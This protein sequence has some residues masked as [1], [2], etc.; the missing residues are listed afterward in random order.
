MLY[1]LKQHLPAY[2]AHVSLPP[3]ERQGRALDQFAHGRPSKSNQGQRADAAYRVALQRARMTH[4][5]EPERL[6]YAE[7]ERILG[8]CMER[9][10]EVELTAITALVVGNTAFL[11]GLCLGQ[12]AVGALAGAVGATSLGATALAALWSCRAAAW[13]AQRYPNG[14]SGGHRLGGG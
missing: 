7:Y 11:A 13:A 6:A 2:V 8:L 9:S 10:S 3:E 4:Q 12:P 5:R 14:R 1:A